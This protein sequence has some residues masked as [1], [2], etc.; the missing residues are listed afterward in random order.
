VD[1][2]ITILK[3]T[4]SLIAGAYGVYA[5]L[6]DFKDEKNGKKVLSRK[7]YFGMGLLISSLVLNLSTD[8]FKDYR[9]HKQ[10]IANDEKQRDMSVKLGQQLGQ[11]T[12]ISSELSEALN[13][14]CNIAGRKGVHEVEEGPF[15][16][17]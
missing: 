9:E 16:R 4:G 13:Q 3:Y 2:I 6:T 14:H 10:E 11:T 15:E 1:I 8:A 5:T 7:G 12:A 17:L